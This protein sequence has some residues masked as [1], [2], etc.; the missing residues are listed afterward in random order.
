MNPGVS[1]LCFF[2]CLSPVV[3]D[4]VYVHP[5]HLFS[6]NKSSCEK[7]DNLTQ[8]EKMFV[9]I[10]IESQT[11]P[12][13]EE[14]L[15]DKTKL[16][17]QSSDTKRDQKL[18][19]L[20]DLVHV[21]GMRFYGALKET[22]KGENILL[23]PTNL[24]RSLLS[25]Y[26]GASE[27]TA[28]DLQ[29]FLGFVPPSGDPDCTSKVDGHKVLLTLKT[30]DDLLF[31]KLSCLFSAPSVRLSK[32]LVHSLAP[33]A[34]YFYARA[35]DFTNPSQAAEL[36]EN[37]VKGK[38]ASRTQNV[39]TNIDPSTTLLFVTY[40]QFKAN[41]KKASQL[42]E[43]QEFWTDSS[44]KTL[45]PMMSI[46]GTF[47]YKRDDS[48]NF[49]VIKVPVSENAFLVLVQ[50]VNSNDLNPIESELSLHPSST[51]LQNLSPR[52]IKLS[53]PELTIQSA[54]DLQELLTNMNLSA[55]LGKKANLTKISDANL[56]VG[57]VINKALFKLKNGVDLPEDFLE[58]NG[59]S[60]PLEVTLNKPFLLA[61]Y[62]KN[63]KAMVLIGRVTNPLNGV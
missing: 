9:P 44:T 24:Y 31:T 39:L 50:P 43:L 60:L 25:F 28:A 54:Y 55:L 15:K 52:H 18:S 6:Y 37:F 8:E 35:V 21:L 11:I 1:L 16:G 59:G 62:E 14:N 2:L 34:D 42:K 10:S 36:I 32:S 27:Q 29:N 48:K 61:V 30:M 47:Q 26:L 40:I 5:F 19:Y 58:E 23:S 53:L 63:S 57:K 4:R 49:S 13:Y 51:W 45:V 46:T 20:K 38:D 12:A 56:T 3:C 22:L 41:V 7:L 17:T 33:S